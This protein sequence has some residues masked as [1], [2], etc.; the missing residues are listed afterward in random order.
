MVCQCAARCLL[1]TRWL[2]QP[3]VGLVCRLQ[4]HGIGHHGGLCH[5]TQSS[6]GCTPI[7]QSIYGTTCSP[8]GST[9]GGPAAILCG[10]WLTW[11]FGWLVA[12]PC[13]DYRTLY[14]PRGLIGFKHV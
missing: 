5:P 14:Y 8:V 11:L 2:D 1:A 4:L 3:M 10:H 7:K 9:R 13:G 6:G 12:G